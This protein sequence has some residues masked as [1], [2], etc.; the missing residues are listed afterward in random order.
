MKTAHLAMLPW[1]MGSSLIDYW[2][3]MPS[4]D[5]KL[6]LAMLC[7]LLPS[8]P[9]VGIIYLPSQ[10]I[11]DHYSSIYMYRFG[12]GNHIYRLLTQ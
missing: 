6:A 7:F 10:L 8:A 4:M 12:S 3:K 2:V 11:Q 5:Y 1:K 9:W